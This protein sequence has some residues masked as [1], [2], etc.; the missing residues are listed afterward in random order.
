M[1]KIFQKMSQKGETKK[2]QSNLQ[3]DY[4]QATCSCSGSNQKQRR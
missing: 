3:K 2:V 4:K 1:P